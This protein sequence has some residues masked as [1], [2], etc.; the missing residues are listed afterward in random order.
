MNGI[1]E[2][3]LLNPLVHFSTVNAH[4]AWRRYAESH[5]VAADVSDRQNDV[6]ADDDLF[7]DVP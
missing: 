2:L 4:G 1:A 7:V 3:I 6:V 5:P